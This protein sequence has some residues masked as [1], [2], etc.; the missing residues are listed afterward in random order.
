[1]FSRRTQSYQKIEPSRE[2]KVKAGLC[3]LQRSGRCSLL[4]LTLTGDNFICEQD[5]RCMPIQ[6]NESKMTFSYLPPASSCVCKCQESQQQTKYGAV[7]FS[8]SMD[9]MY[10]SMTKELRVQ[11]LD[12]RTINYRRSEQQEQT[13]MAFT[14]YACPS[15]Y[16]GNTDT[17]CVIKSISRSLLQVKYSC[18]TSELQPLISK[19]SLF[20]GQSKSCSSEI[21]IGDIADPIIQCRYFLHNLLRDERNLLVP[22][23][24][25]IDKRRDAVSEQDVNEREGLLEILKEYSSL[26]HLQSYCLF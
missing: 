25:Q 2:E 18:C 1:M 5:S 9:V 6:D 11:G 17:S 16:S 3:F 15:L 14:R 21:S 8:P 24:S 23:K 4:T 19:E 26:K 20:V 7:D 12:T 10:P 13:I 22:E